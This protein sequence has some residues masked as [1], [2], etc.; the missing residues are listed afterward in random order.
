M[1]QY[2]IDYSEV[3]VRTHKCTISGWAAY[4]EPLEIY[5]ENEDKERMKFSMERV[6]R[7]EVRTLY[8]EFEIGKQC[9]FFIEV[10]IENEKGLRVVFAAKNRRTIRYISLQK[11]KR[12][13]E[14]AGNYCEKGVRY[15]KNYGAV[16]FVKKVVQKAEGYRNRPSLYNKWYPKHMA[17]QQ[18]LEKQRGTAFAYEPLISIVIPLY[19]TPIPYLKEL[20]DSVQAQTYR[21]F[22][23]CLADGSD[24]PKTGDYIREHYGKDSR[25]EPKPPVRSQSES[26]ASTSRPLYRA[27]CSDEH[28]SA[29]ILAGKKRASFR[30]HAGSFSLICR[31]ERICSTANGTSIPGYFDAL[32]NRRVGSSEAWSLINWRIESFCLIS[33]SGKRGSIGS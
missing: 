18:E 16:E 14:K 12:M 30:Y 4:Q 29:A 11:H 27:V 25:I 31:R 20:L 10:P 32:S 5:V 15:L 8:H 28:C 3:N 7:P 21:N 22:Q 9:G 26:E 33:I 23:L 17:S 19:N 24:N 6:Y 1:P 2:C 13:G